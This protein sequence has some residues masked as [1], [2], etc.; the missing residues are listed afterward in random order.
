M[1]N[2]QELLDVYKELVNNLS[3]NET[4]EHFKKNK[5][6][7]Y[8]LKEFETMM[9]KSIKSYEDMKRETVKYH[10]LHSNV[11]ELVNVINSLTKESNK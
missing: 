11:E 2:K 4:H 9:F 6:E 5:F 3:N 10:E 7:K 8:S 1:N